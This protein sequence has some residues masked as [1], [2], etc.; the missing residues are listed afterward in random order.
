MLDNSVTYLV[1]NGFDGEFSNI[2]RFIREK[3]RH[4]LNRPGLLELETVGIH[5]HGEFEGKKEKEIHQNLKKHV[6]NYIERG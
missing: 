4:L 3:T 1:Q 2:A 6:K 5:H